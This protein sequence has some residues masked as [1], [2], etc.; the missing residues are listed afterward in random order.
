MT[1]EPTRAQRHANTIGHKTASS[2]RHEHWHGRF[3]LRYVCSCVCVLCFP[4]W[5]LATEKSRRETNVRPP[6][7]F[8]PTT[9]AGQLSFRDARFAHLR[10]RMLLAVWCLCC[11][12][13]ARALTEK[14]ARTTSRQHHD[15]QGNPGTPATSGRAT[16]SS[17]GAV[18]AFASRVVTRSRCRA[19]TVF[20]VCAWGPPRRLQ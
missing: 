7:S 19:K 8:A 10:R 18:Y 11:R 4:P 16:N 14:S 15:S 17:H 5:E 13:T 12:W 9:P 20:R 2:P 1:E 6:R 3:S